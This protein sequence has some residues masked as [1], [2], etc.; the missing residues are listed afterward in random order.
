MSLPIDICMITC[1]R[2]RISELSITEIKHRTL[3]PHRL[4]V[5][6]NG[7]TDNTPEMLK[8]LHK[9]NLIDALILWP[10]N[11]GVHFAKNLLLDMVESELFVSTD[12]DI[13]PQ[14]RYPSMNSPDWLEYLVRI[15]AA[16]PDYAAISATPHVFIGASLPPDPPSLWERSHVG[17]VLRMMD[18]AATRATGGWR[19]EKDPGR[20]NEEWWICERLRKQDLK[21]GYATH[22][23]AIHLFGDEERGEDPWGYPGI[24]RPQDHGHREIWPPVNHSSYRRLNIDWH[25]CRPSEGEDHA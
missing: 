8:R 4:I 5:L 7:S 18:T 10:E 22:I 19:N 9:E 11:T 6:D 17:S 14:A 3:T 13:V 21:V 24:M 2:A 23:K 25:T 15:M 12:D 1:N 20:D 16:N